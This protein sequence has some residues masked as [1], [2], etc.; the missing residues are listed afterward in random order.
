MM[1]SSTLHAPT[2][3]LRAIVCLVLLMTC[4]S[5]SAENPARKSAF[6][7]YMAQYEEGLNLTPE[8]SQ[9]MMP[10][11]LSNGQAMREVV[12]RNSH[13]GKGPLT[14]QMRQ[15]RADKIERE[16]GAVREQTIGKLSAILTPQQLEAY[17]AMEND[18][19]QGAKKLLKARGS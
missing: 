1:I 11:L 9:M 17:R 2:A 3:M 10:I 12:K 16:M 8:Q 4:A 19:R 15:L 5:V 14:E 13:A 7:R 6:A 18:R